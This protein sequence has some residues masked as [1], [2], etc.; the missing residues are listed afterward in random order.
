MLLDVAYYVN[1]AIENVN[2]NLT[3]TAKMQEYLIL[4]KKEVT[5]CVCSPV[6]I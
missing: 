2:I 6:D 5:R 1:F 3:M 4:V